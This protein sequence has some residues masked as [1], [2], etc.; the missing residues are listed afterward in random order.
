M[1]PEETMQAGLLALKSNRAQE[2]VDQFTAAIEHGLDADLQN[3]ARS[4]RAQ[5]YML[6]GNTEQAI[7]DWREAWRGVQEAGDSTGVTALRNLRKDIARTKA[8]NAA[9]HQQRLQSK[10]LIEKGISLAQEAPREEQLN[11]LLELANAHMDCESWEEGR[12]LAETIIEEA[13]QHLKTLV[14]FSILGRL[15]LIR[16]LTEH[17]GDHL[18]TALT[19]AD[20]ANE[21]QLIG[22][23]ARAA[24][25]IG[26]EFPAIEF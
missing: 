17:Q 26:Y 16:A 15:C 14:R 10:Q 24:K 18:E 1:T 13:D 22:A 9:A 25:A 21:M 2:A 20:E 11:S 7:V 4:L 5:S 8:N 23:V 12:Q 6:L 3:R 19:L